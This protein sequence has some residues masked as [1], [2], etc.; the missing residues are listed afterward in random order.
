MRWDIGLPSFAEVRASAA[1]T[2]DSA[3][4]GVRDF[5]GAA[6]ERGADLGRAGLDLGRQAVEAVGSIDVR[7]AAQTVRQGIGEAAEAGRAGIS[8]GVAWA[9]A[10]TGAAAD[11]ARG[12]IGGDDLVSQAARGVITNAENQTRF[13]IGVVGGVARE[14][15]GTAGVAGQ[16]GTTLVEMQVSGE[17]RVEY[18]QRIA[19]G[20]ADLATSAATYVDGAVRDPSSVGRDLG[21]VVDAG[22]RFVDGQVAR[23]DAA[24][25]SGQGAETLGMDVGTV[26]TYLVPI[27]GGPARGAVTA[28]AREGAEAVVREGTQALVREGSEALVREGVVATRAS[29]T[30][31][32]LQTGARQ[33][34]DP[35]SLRGW[36]RAEAAY[37]TIRESTTDVAAISRSTGLPESQVSRIKDHLFYKEHQLDAG[38]ARFDADPGIVNAWSR[39]ERGDHVASDLDLLRHEIFE[40]RFEGIF[41]TNYRTAHDATIR[42][43]RTW[44]GE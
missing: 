27:G 39:L 11:F 24:I 21:N 26:A 37:V 32:M 42:S 1:R 44:T 43:G 5:G 18:G 30:G 31:S 16:L 14:V 15:V 8:D 2:L 6:V 40:S 33:V 38:L 34:L 10:R 13:G 17:A 12:Q 28:V 19:S 20:A 23:Y 3:V 41:G 35:Q 22:G 29:G 9:S 7:A 4:D 36:D 25:R